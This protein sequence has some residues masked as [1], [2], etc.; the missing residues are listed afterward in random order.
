MLDL[1]KLITVQVVSESFP[2]SSSG[3]V[4][5]ALCLVA[6]KNMLTYFSLYNFLQSHDAVIWLNLPTVFVVALFF[7]REWLFLLF[8][9]Q[10][11]WRIVL[12]L[13]FYM[14]CSNIVTTICFFIIRIYDLTIPLW[15]GFGITLLLLFSLRWCRKSSHATLTIPRTLLLGLIQGMA[16]L[17]GI[18]RFA[19]VF[20]ASRWMG[21]SNRRSF[22]IAWML[23][24]PISLGMLFL[25]IG[26]YMVQQT[27]VLPLDLPLIMT[28]IIASTL[29]FIGMY[30]MYWLVRR[31]MLW[32][33]SG[34]MILPFVLS[35]LY[36]S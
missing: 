35:I 20:V 36:C 17:Q 33:M 7:A 32:I 15:L 6:Y 11:T 25:N 18:S 9:I 27:Y 1:L 21:I 19:V 30:S 3:H 5:L 28:M 26:Q 31:D 34:Y 12:K 13:I 10:Y 23:Q 4:A 2:V 8:N 22:F 29:A 16:L 14:L 24:W